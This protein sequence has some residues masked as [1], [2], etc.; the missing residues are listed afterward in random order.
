MTMNMM[1]PGQQMPQQ[2]GAGQPA[3]AAAPATTPVATTLEQRWA[4]YFASPSIRA[5]AL[6]FGIGMMQP[7]NPGQT[8][9]GHTALAIGDA[10]QAA[11]RTGAF[12]H[13]VA[14]DQAELAQGQQTIDIA[15]DRNTLGREELTVRKDEAKATREAAAAKA[16]YDAGQDKIKN[17]IDARRAAA[18][19]LM[20]SKAGASAAAND[21]V[22]KE[23]LDLLANIAQDRALLEGEDFD[24]IAYFDE[25]VGKLSGGATPAAQG[26]TGAAPAAPQPGQIVEEGGKKYKFVGGNPAD[27][28]AW[29]EVK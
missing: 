15:R 22:L 5:A 24:P 4:N 1:P 7:V 14:T 25:Q 2:P 17:A 28:N 6:Q 3:A 9:G 11:A 27:P 16:T 26:G 21:P 10:A 18:Y 13:K 20:A 29:Q 12:Q 23:R 8:F 19:E